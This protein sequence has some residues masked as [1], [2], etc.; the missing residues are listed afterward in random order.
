[1]S[2]VGPPKRPDSTASAATFD[3]RTLLGRTRRDHF[4][5]KWLVTAN[6][7]TSMDGFERKGTLGN[8]GWAT[9]LTA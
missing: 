7:K 8:A 6:A 2:A 3:S 1:M 5:P 4:G 9:A